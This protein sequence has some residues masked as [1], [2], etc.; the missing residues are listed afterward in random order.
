MFLRPSGLIRFRQG[1]YSGAFLKRDEESIANLYRSNGF[2]DVK[3]NGVAEDDP[4]GKQGDVA[5]RI[6]V[7]EGPQWTVSKLS[8]AGFDNLPTQDL[9]E[10]LASTEGQPFSDVSVAADRT[11]ILT[12][13]QQAGFPDAQFAWNSML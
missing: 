2:Q 12:E 3:V 9:R 8:F 10:R 1:R 7:E 11:L 13:Y 5:V 6:S 4:Q